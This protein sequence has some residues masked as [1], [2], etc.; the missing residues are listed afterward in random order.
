MSGSELVFHMRK[1]V[2]HAL[3]LWL[4][5]LLFKEKICTDLSS[6]DLVLCFVFCWKLL[7]MSSSGTRTKHVCLTLC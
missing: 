1:Y 4:V 2:V 5:D 6:C 3:L 7:G